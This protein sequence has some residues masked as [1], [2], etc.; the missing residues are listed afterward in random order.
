MLLWFFLFIF[1][2]WIEKELIKSR[3]N[4][5]KK[6]HSFLYYVKSFPYNQISFKRL[7]NILDIYLACLIISEFQYNKKNT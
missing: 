3:Y 1:D 2:R 7:L 5:I 4:F 6:N